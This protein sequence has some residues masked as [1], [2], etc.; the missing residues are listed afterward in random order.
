MLNFAAAQLQRTP[1]SGISPHTLSWI[2]QPVSPSQSAQINE[3][4]MRLQSLKVERD[5][6][7]I[8]QQEIRQ[9]LLKLQI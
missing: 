1:A 7:K 8:R 4:N 6:L 3:A 5:R 2:Q 9:V